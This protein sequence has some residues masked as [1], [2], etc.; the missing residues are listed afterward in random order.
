MF[1]VVVLAQSIRYEV[2]LSR[3]ITLSLPFAVINVFYGVNFFAGGAII[4][5]DSL[6]AADWKGTYILILA[7]LAVFARTIAGRKTAPLA[8]IILFCGILAPLQKPVLATFAFA[9]LLL[10]FLAFRV[11]RSG[12]DIRIGKTFILIIILLIIGAIGG[13]IIFGLGNEAASRF[14][15]ERILKGGGEGKDLSGGRLRMWADC[16]GIWTEHPVLGT[17]LGHRLYG[18]GEDGIPFALP[19]HNL[20]IQILMETG[21]M[22]FL[23][24]ILAVGGWFHRASKTLTWETSSDRLWPRLV[25][26]T[27]V[28]TM[29]FSVLYGE[30]LT[31][32]PVAFIFW[33]ML[34]FESAGIAKCFNGIKSPKIS[35]IKFRRISSHG[36]SLV[37]ELHEDRIVVM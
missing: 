34:A 11:R 16:L 32:M 1:W 30:S 24:L 17:G 12:G 18:M 3:F 13:S 15:V 7:Y 4:S 20:Y 29:L 28:A 5:K 21:L 26:I 14:L 10:L 9:N 8:M 19:V 36:K 22:G 37:P 25:I 31:I 23:T 27:W 2:I 6:F 33:M 35:L